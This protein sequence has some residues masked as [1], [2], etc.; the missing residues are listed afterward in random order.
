AT[1]HA[2]EPPFDHGQD[3]RDRDRRVRRRSSGLQHRHA[4]AGRLLVSAYHGLDVPSFVRLGT[5][6]ALRTVS[7]GE[8]GRRGPTK[9]LAPGAT[10]SEVALQVQ[11]EAPCRLAVL[12][13]IDSKHHRT[14][15][16]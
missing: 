2:G 13:R 8:R 14:G 1:E 6:D 12:P 16:V 4:R 15:R 5:D 10:G 3:R 7:T 11:M 9:Y